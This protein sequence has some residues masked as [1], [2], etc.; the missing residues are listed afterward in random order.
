MAS[1]SD[2]IELLE[3][4]GREDLEGLIDAFARV[5]GLAGGVVRHP[6]PGERTPTAARRMEEWR[7]TKVIGQSDFC[8]IV[9][10]TAE[11]NRRC[12]W[13]DLA[14]AREAGDRRDAI[15][16]EC[17]M[18]LT[19]VVAPIFVA[20]KHV[21]NVYLGGG[22]PEDLPLVTAWETYLALAGEIRG[23][24]SV[25]R[26]ELRSA[27]ELLPRVPQDR[28]ESIRCLTSRLAELISQRATRQA[29]LRRLAEI[30]ERLGPSVNLRRGA[31]EF[32]SLAKELTAAD[33]GGVYLVKD[34]GTALASE[35]LDYGDV[36]AG[37]KLEIPLDGQ[38]LV[39]MAAQRR[40]PLVLGSRAAIEAASPATHPEG[41]GARRLGSFLGAPMVHAGKVVGVIDLGSH[42][43]GAF[44]E[45][46]DHLAR[47]VAAQCASFVASSKRRQEI[48]RIF[49]E[50]SVGERANVLARQVPLLVDGTGCSI[51]LRRGGSEE[52]Y[53]YA[54]DELLVNP[55]LV[56]AAYY[57]P[58][59]G[60][61]GW[62][63][64]S[65]RPL[66]IPGGKGAR[67]RA[68][69]RQIDVRLKW[70]AK[71]RGQERSKTSF[72]DRPYLAVPV[73]DRDGLVIGVI[74][75][76]DKA[77]GDE[78]DGRDEETLRN[79]AEF[80][81][82]IV[83]DQASP[84]KPAAPPMPK[85]VFLSHGHDG[86]VAEE[87]ADFLDRL[88]GLEVIRATRASARGQDMMYL[89]EAWAQECAVAVVVATA[90]DE[91]RVSTVAARK[92][93]TATA[94]AQERVERRIRPNVAHEMGY[95]QGSLGNTRVVILEERG[96]QMPSNVQGLL[97]LRFRIGNVKE[98]FGDLL[99]Y[100]QDIGVVPRPS[101]H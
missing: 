99:G 101:T 33:T 41:R 65:G 62:V 29:T 23:A 100:L 49:G 88:L 78:F 14:F 85:T 82:V 95:F 39:V 27:F 28:W 36:A 59:E 34:D 70:A 13:D 2:R 64:G 93:A 86:S 68:K 61:T 10:K 8:C 67:S 76:S 97:T 22:R 1:A 92:K 63:L 79:F 43:E 94:P 17:Y 46:D 84:R 5:T 77:T 89:L 87:V 75:V 24:K 18:G 57:K 31:E 35:V 81:A 25:T 32:Y 12:M 56:S 71:F 4:I 40:K 83:G 7:L 50:P 91:C 21:A 53:L 72:A 42:D 3:A 11:G 47:L 30:H 98:V 69:L 60:L 80:L 38:G 51:F 55:G 16:Y 58:W 19:T 74:R 9:R 52:A 20:G 66:R 45:E 15:L 37:R 26:K 96:A 44:S 54:T 73:T 90:D 48:I 6:A